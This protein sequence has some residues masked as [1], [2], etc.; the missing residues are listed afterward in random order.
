MQLAQLPYFI[1]FLKFSGLFD[2]LVADCPLTCRSPNAPKVRDVLG[3][4]MLSILS[5]YKRYAH[6]MALRGDGVLPELLGKR[7]IASVD[8]VRWAL[9]AIPE[10]EG[11]TWLQRHLDRCTYPLL[12]EP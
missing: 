9:A 11:T 5:G 3:T 2:A 8:P 7:K 12:A 4:M 10:P 1:D 6:I